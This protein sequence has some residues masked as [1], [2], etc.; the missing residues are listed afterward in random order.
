RPPA[1]GIDD[2]ALV[3][4]AGYDDGLAIEERLALRCRAPQQLPG[5]TWRAFRRI[6]LMPNS[7]MDAVGPDQYARLIDLLRSGLTVREADAHAI[8]LLLEFAEFQ[9]APNI[10]IADA[11]AD[12][13][14]QQMLKLAAMNR[15]LRP[16]VSGGEASGFFMDELAELVAK[17]KPPRS[18]AGRRK[19]A[20]EPE[21]GEFSD[22]G[23]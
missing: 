13:A 12:G 4:M 17:I 2:D 10:F 9:S 1:D 21:F 5:E 16:A 3:E 6:E 20:S 11:L 19:G 18:D 14:K 15:I 23:W 8:S 22:R 7:G